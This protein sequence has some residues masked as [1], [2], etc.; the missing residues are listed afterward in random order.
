M[1]CS[2]FTPDAMRAKEVWPLRGVGPKK[3]RLRGQGGQ[4]S[5]EVLICFVEHEKRKRGKKR[6]REVEDL[7]MEDKRIKG[8]EEE[9]HIRQGALLHQMFPKKEWVYV[10]QRDR[11]E[12][13]GENTRRERKIHRKRSQGGIIGEGGITRTIRAPERKLRGE[14][15]QDN[16]VGEY[17][18]DEVDH[19]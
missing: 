4:K 2:N 8:R 11:G 14:R 17:K 12:Q 1:H 13:V 18:D 3:K 19:D 9:R 10:S 16:L 7:S 6:K 15:T 5:K